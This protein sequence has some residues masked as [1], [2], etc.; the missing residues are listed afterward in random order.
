[1]R[2]TQR[3]VSL[4]EYVITYLQEEFSREKREATAYDVREWM[5]VRVD[6]AIDA[7]K[8]GTR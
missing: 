2:Q 6:D 8:G 5:T 7:Y 1:M 4:L 3:E